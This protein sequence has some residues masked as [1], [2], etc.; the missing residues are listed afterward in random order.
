MT[1]FYKFAE[2]HPGLTVVL[3]IIALLT[4]DA[5]TTNIASAFHHHTCVCKEDKE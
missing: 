2:A 4:L 3:A 5:V 1:E